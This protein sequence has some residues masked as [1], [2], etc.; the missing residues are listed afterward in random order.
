V[1]SLLELPA[2]VAKNNNDIPAG[3]I[4]EMVVAGYYTPYIFAAADS[5]P[6]HKHVYVSDRC[7]PFKVAG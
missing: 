6:P 3:K 1:K 7:T 5:N 2:I 4:L